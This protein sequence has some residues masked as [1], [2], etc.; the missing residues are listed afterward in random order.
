MD[1]SRPGSKHHLLTDGNG[2]PLVVQLTAANH[3]D[4]N[5][6]YPL[7]DGIPPLRG[8]RGRPRFRP[9]RVYGDRGFDSKAHR[10]GLRL[11]GIQP[12]LA[13]RNTEHGSGLGLFRWVVERT[14]SWLHQH[15]RLRVRFERRP[16]L[17]EALLS[18]GATLICW[19]FIRHSL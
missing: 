10:I 3:P 17:H 2:I 4:V 14:A 5:Q 9:R 15:R 1:R 6:L 19:S 7:V 11:R 13:R 18:L 12:F 8:A 16:E